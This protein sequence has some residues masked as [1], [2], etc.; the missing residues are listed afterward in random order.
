[1]QVRV[2]CKCVL[3]FV[4]VSADYGIGIGQH[5]F[6]GASLLYVIDDR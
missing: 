3:F 1:M 4:P 2:T 6:I 5:Y